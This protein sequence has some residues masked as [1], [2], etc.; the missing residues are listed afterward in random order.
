MRVKLDALRSSVTSKR[1]RISLPTWF[2]LVIILSYDN[3]SETRRLF[4][5]QATKRIIHNKIHQRPSAQALFISRNRK[6][7][8]RASTMSQTANTSPYHCTEITCWKIT[9]ETYRTATRDGRARSSYTSHG[10]GKMPDW[11][12]DIH[13]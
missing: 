5:S 8:L 3:F 11:E 1:V 7:T 2:L 13:R 6:A 10:S 4:T 9:Q 12:A